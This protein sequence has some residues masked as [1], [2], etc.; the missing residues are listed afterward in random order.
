MNWLINCMV[1]IGSALMVYNIYCFVTYARDLQKKKDWG[2]ERAILFLPIFLLIFFLIGYLVVG[3][4]GKPDLVV[5]G[6]LFGGS[7]FVL[8]MAK[9]LQFI[10][11]RVQE[12]EHMRA[13]LLAAEESGKVKTAFLSRVSHEM[14]TPL[15]VI[16]GLDT[17]ALKNKNLMP[18]TRDQ[19][20]KIGISASHLLSL[21]DN[22]LDMSSFD[23][24]QIVL[25]EEKFSMNKVLDLMNILM[26][27]KCKENGLEYHSTVIG[28]LDGYYIGDETRL[29]QVLLNI[30]D[31]AVKFTPA[32]GTVTFTTEQISVDKQ[33]CSLRFIIS[34]TGVGIA[35]EFIPHLFDPFAQEDTGAT[36]RYGGSGLGMAIAKNIVDAMDGQITVKS[37]KGSWSTFTITVNLKRCSEIINVDNQIV[38]PETEPDIEGIISGCR[39]LI[40]EDMDLNAEI[41][42][43]LL[44][45][46]DVS[47][48]RAENGE[49]AVEMYTKSPENYYDAI[50]MDIRMPMMDGLDA[51][52]KIR[53]LERPD[54]VVVPIIA[55]SANA[56]DAD[57]QNSLLAGM[58]THLS[59]P[60]DSEKLY[61]TLA[62]LISNNRKMAKDITD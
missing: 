55:L 8:V 16:I 45:M 5:S 14:R 54:A 29:K 32:P 35:D 11:N 17:I 39:M 59:K 19:L 4:F 22:V 58:N 28:K 42:A 33:I 49:I 3:I 53:A 10:T 60:V 18:E 12:N 40:V 21:I 46:E 25:K 62:K 61:E 44:E 13:K 27:N 43:D 15:N 23:S 36:N 30:L 1:Y 6:I 37:K 9:L 26:Q 47:S 2:K 24:N 20:E 57:R 34:D 52:R 31:N 48:E 41:L 7:L 50:L 56:S 38:E 51:T